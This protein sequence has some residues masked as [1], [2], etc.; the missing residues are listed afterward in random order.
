MTGLN[1]PNC[2]LGGYVDSSNT[3]GE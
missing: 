1:E 3:S 2:T